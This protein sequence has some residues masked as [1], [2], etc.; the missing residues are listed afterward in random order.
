MQPRRK[1]RRNARGPPSS[2]EALTDEYFHVR[3]ETDDDFNQDPGDDWG[4]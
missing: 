3:P 2:T 1:C 4:L